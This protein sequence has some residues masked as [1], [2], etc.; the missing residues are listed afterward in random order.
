MR[1]SNVEE[2]RRWI[3]TAERD[4]KSAKNSLKSGDYPVACFWAQQSAEKALKGFLLYVGEELIK[5]HAVTDLNREAQKYDPDFSKIYP[6]TNG[7]DR[8]YIPTRYPNSVPT[9]TPYDIYD[10]DSAKEAVKQAR[11]VIDLVLSKVDFGCLEDD[12]ED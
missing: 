6:S 1:R 2:A 10:L 8:L 7:L 4:L 5:G 9:T 3:L 11:V 12:T